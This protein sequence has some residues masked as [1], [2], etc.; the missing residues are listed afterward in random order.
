MAR[1]NSQTAIRPS[2]AV[3]EESCPLEVAYLEEEVQEEEF[4]GEEASLEAAEAQ[5]E[6]G[7]DAEAEEE[8]P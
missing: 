2:E 1:K 8:P 3:Q 7:P 6:A 5:E 4:H